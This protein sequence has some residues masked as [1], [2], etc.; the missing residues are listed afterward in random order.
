M[1]SLLIG[2]SASPEL[3]A[4]IEAELERGPRVRRVIHTL[5]QHTGPDELLV[6]AKVEFDPELTTPQLVD[7]INACEARVRAIAGTGR[8]DLRR[9]GHRRA[10]RPSPSRRPA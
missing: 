10:A 2:E 3:Q 9:A 4:Q 8:A 6:A 5:T 7:A 1:R